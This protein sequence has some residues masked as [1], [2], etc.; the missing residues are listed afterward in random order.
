MTWNLELS[1]C[2]EK[3]CNGTRA[4]KGHMSLKREKGEKIKRSRQKKQVRFSSVELMA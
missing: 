4:F 2:A 1:Q 3:E